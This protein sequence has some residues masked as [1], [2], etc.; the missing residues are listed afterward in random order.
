MRM[1]IRMLIFPKIQGEISLT[2]M[3]KKKKKTTRRNQLDCH[4][5]EKEK[6]ND[7]CCKP[8]ISFTGAGYNVDDPFGKPDIEQ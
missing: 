2:A 5:E 1:P 3:P 7:T 6:D 4:A 8:D